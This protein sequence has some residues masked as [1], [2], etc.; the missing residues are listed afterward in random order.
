[1]LL[2]QGGPW[3]AGKRA[4]ERD[5]DRDNICSK[6]HAGRDLKEST[7]VLYV[8]SSELKDLRVSFL[9]AS[10]ADQNCC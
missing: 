4:G 2:S 5:G 9:V 8:L 7:S 6:T 10:S 3:V 1:M